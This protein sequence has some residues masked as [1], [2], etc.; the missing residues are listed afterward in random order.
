[1]RVACGLYLPDQPRYAS[2]W[3]G[4][5]GD[6][7][8]SVIAIREHV[9]P[10]PGEALHGAQEIDRLRRKR[11]DVFL[12]LLHALGGMH[13]IAASRSNSCQRA[14]TTSLGRH[15]VSHIKRKAATV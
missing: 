6:G 7:L 4:R 5:I 13:Q 9:R 14:P 11:D 1:M 2:A 3:R 15:R 12:A 10:M 8:V